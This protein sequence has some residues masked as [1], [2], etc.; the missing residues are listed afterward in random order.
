MH[1][2][3]DDALLPAHDALLHLTERGDA[4][5]RDSAHEAPLALL[6]ADV[7]SVTA[8]MRAY[9]ARADARR[10]EW[11][12]AQ[13]R[14]PPSIRPIR[15][16][17][18][19]LTLFAPPLCGLCEALVSGPLQPICAACDDCALLRVKRL[20]F[21]PVYSAFQHTDT[22]RRAVT[23]LKYRGDRWR[24]HSLGQHLALQWLAQTHHEIDRHDVLVP[25]PLSTTRIKTRRFNQALVVAE[26]LRRRTGLR[27]HTQLLTR[28]ETA[29]GVQLDQKRR[30]RDDRLAQTGLFVS[31][32]RTTAQRVWLVDDVVTTGATLVD[33]AR[34]LETVGIRVAGALTLTWTM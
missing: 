24:G 26:G 25:V 3:R 5:T 16:Y 8:E 21:G 27:V 30:N 6:P 12:A 14:R 22:A 10:Q 19:L 32:G 2:L 15:A 17:E 28:P 33:A 18:H 7:L 20:H 13:E 29:G 34:A 9:R 31:T 1:T 11:E 4:D 23:N